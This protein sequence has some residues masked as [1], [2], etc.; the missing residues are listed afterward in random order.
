VFVANANTVINIR[1]GAYVI[2]TLCIATLMFFIVTHVV[3]QSILVATIAHK[4]TL[5]AMI[6]LAIDTLVLFLKRN[7]HLAALA[8]PVPGLI[9]AAPLAM[10]AVRTKVALVVALDTRPEVLA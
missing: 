1:V 7:R 2:F 4:D 8:N 3:F 6:R 9:S 5:G 10:R